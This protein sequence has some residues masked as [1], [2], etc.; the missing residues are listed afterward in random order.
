ML[1]IQYIY[2]HDFAHCQQDSWHV[3]PT[4]LSKLHRLS[5]RI[6]A[7]LL[8]AIKKCVATTNL[9]RQQH[10]K[11]RESN[12]RWLS[13]CRALMWRRDDNLCYV[14]LISGS[15]QI[16]DI[17]TCSTLNKPDEVCIS[18]QQII[19]NGTQ[20]ACLLMCELVWEPSFRWI[21]LHCRQADHCS[22]SHFLPVA[23][24]SLDAWPQSH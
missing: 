7:D 19:M 9:M 15:P 12:V 1:A 24:L 3:M 21:N 2:K 6:L 5:Q 17:A 11:C 8:C 13:P 14:L 10:E 23:L 16:G 22:S 18:S 20:V 4:D